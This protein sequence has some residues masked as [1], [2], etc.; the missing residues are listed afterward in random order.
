MITHTDSNVRTKLK[1]H[2]PRCSSQRTTIS[3][4]GLWAVDVAGRFLVCSYLIQSRAAFCQ[5]AKTRGDSKRP[6]CRKLIRSSS[7]PLMQLFPSRPNTSS[8]MGHSLTDLR[9]GGLN[10]DGFKG[11]YRR[12]LGKRGVRVS[13]E[14]H[15]REREVRKI[16]IE[17]NSFSLFE[18]EGAT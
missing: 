7:K 2:T 1:F 10:S 15:L 4:E 11:S 3:I 8:N 17:F 6:Q 14:V 5:L 9:A 18:K 13:W 16:V 12:C